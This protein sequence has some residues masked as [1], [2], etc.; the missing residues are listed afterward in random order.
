L[1]LRWRKEAT[2]KPGAA[3]LLRAWVRNPYDWEKL[4]IMGIVSTFV[5][6]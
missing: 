5:K 3:Y 1:S 2:K 4:E 6:Y